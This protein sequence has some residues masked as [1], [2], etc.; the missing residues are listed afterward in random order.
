MKDWANTKIL[1]QARRLCITPDSGNFGDRSDALVPV[2]GRGIDVKRDGMAGRSCWRDVR[3]P[4]GTVFNPI[5]EVVGAY[6]ESDISDKER[7]G[8]DLGL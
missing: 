1:R 7:P 6:I 8:A 3:C 5:N 4:C 2:I